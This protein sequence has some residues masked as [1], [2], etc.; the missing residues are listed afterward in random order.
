MEFKEIISLERGNLTMLVLTLFAWFVLKWCDVFYL[1]YWIGVE[2]AFVVYL[3]GLY[4]IYLLFSILYQW[5]AIQRRI[6]IIPSKEY[7]SETFSEPF[8]GKNFYG[9]LEVVIPNKWRIT[10][11]YVTLDNI[12]PIYYDDK[13][14][15][16]K[17]FHEWLSSNMNPDYKL[18]LWKSPLSYQYR[19]KIDIGEN[20]NKEVFSV[21]KIITGKLTD[22]NGL[23][24]DIN[25]FNFCTAKINQDSL[26]FMKFGLYAFIIKFHWQRGGREMIGKKIDGYIYSRVEGPIQEI[27]VGVGDYNNDK[28][29]PKPLLKVEEQND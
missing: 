28:D 7:Y 9:F 8:K 27:R 14:Y 12:V 17:E 18:L 13:V 3:I 23:I 26:D 4:F 24:A 16:G 1:E 21:G 6:K 11:C 2:F 10:N 29:V 15:I 19:T 20:S 22:T 25:T 5:F